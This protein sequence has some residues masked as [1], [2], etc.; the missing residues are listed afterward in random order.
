MD[1]TA[2]F[3]A[4]WTRYQKMALDA[5]PI[6]TALEAE[7]ET[8]LNDHVAYRT[9]QIPGLS[10]FELGSFF[11][12]LGYERHPEDLHFPEKKLIAN[13]WLP[14]DPNLPRVFISELILNQIS[15]PCASWIRS[16][17]EP[18]VRAKPPINA[19]TFLEPT[20]PAISFE[21]YQ[22]FSIESE[23]AAWTACFGIQLNHFTVSVN[24][25]KKYPTVAELNVFLESKGFQLNSQG[26]KIKGRPEEFLV[27]SSTM[28]Q[29]IP[30]R[31]SGNRTEPAMG[32]YYEFA[33][34]YPLPSGEL[35]QG[36]IPKSA[37]KIFEST[38]ET[39]T[40]PTRD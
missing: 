17:T 2:F 30:V 21:D 34:R 3:Q 38:F 8:V 16:V 35:F 19:H 4:S 9:F 31:F 12:T 33:R 24:A 39:K 18:F 14:K 5:Q 28:A 11:E 7:G 6:V 27:Q 23:Y 22:R 13:Y 40:K 1:A 10:R 36:F 32:C 29:R 20:W 26:G 25:L 15:S 37:D